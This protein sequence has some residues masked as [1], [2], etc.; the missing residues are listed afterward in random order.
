M[1]VI[2]NKEREDVVQQRK[3]ASPNRLVIGR[4][5][6]ERK[7]WGNHMTQATVGFYNRRCGRHMTRATQ[8][9][10]D[11]FRHHGSQVHIFFF[12]FQ[13]I[14]P[15]CQLKMPYRLLK[16]SVFTLFQKPAVD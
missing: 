15:S 2:L 7:I 6:L 5:T 16:F 11:D 4:L 1:S 3:P 9:K 10:D 14:D 8:N 12:I 13:P